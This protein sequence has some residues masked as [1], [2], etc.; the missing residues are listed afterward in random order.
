MAYSSSP[1]STHDKRVTDAHRLTEEI[2]EAIGA[3]RVNDL[4][5]SL[6]QVEGPDSTGAVYF[7]VDLAG[8]FVDLYISS[9][10]RRSLAA[11]A[12]GPAV[13]EAYNYARDK[14]GM[15][16]LILRHHGVRLDVPLT[17]PAYFDQHEPPMPPSDSP[18]AL[19]AIEEKLRSGWR[20]L[21]EVESLLAA[22]DADLERTVSSPY[23]MV[24]ATVRGSHVVRLDVDGY[25]A[26]NADVDRLTAEVR[27]VFTSDERR[28]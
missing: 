27:A 20:I 10:W 28:Q 8:H 25:A 23:G 18:D 5:R 2:R 21:D 15:I 12:L 16:P 22:S 6:G 7:I 13:L 19:G 3:N 24:R 11:G 26:E 4:V 9:D 14:A 17:A 1:P